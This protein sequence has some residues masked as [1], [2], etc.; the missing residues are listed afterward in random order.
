MGATKQYYVYIL[1]NRTR[2]LYIGV[3]N[4]LLR[5]VFEH[6]QKLVPGFTSTYNLT[7]LAYYE[8]TDDI[9]SAISR[10][11]QVKTWGRTKKMALVETMNP[12]WQDLSAE[13][14]DSP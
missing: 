2:R 11:K 3:T 7:W 5:R 14:Y 1:T 8:A 10:E 13:W 9:H 12:N 4:D 6:K